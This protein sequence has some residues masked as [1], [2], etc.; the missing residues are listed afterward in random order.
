MSVFLRL[1]IPPVVW[2]LLECT[3]EILLSLK[4]NSIGK[5]RVHAHSMMALPSVGPDVGWRWDRDGR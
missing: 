5:S 2:L 4:N 3:L 1:I